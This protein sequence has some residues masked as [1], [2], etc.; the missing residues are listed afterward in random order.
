MG[1]HRDL[2]FEAEV[3]D[4]DLDIS[5]LGMAYLSLFRMTIDDDQMTLTR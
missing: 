1:P 5:L 4:G 3:N 2:E